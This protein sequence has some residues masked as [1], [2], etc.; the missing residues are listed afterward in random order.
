MT[1]TATETAAAEG[2]APGQSAPIRVILR[3]EIFPEM[4]ADFEKVWLTIGEAIATEPANL[5]QTLV[6]SNEAV[7]L[8][9]VFTEWTT[10]KEFRDFEVSAR[11]TLHRQKL[12][13]Y[14]RAGVM[15]VTEVVFRLEPAGQ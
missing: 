1:A 6:K 7:G 10:E 15:D 9:F 12:K 14:R 3:M 8:Y 4:A 11:H 2:S 13:P 5:G